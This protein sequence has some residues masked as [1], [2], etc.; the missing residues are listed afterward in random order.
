LFWVVSQI[1]RFQLDTTDDVHIEL[2]VVQDNLEINL[3]VLN[4][5]DIVS[6]RNIVHNWME[7]G[8]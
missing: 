3:I 6:K 7:E 1:N 4:Y 2:Q 8:F 5:T